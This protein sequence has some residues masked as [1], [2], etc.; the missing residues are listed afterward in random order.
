MPPINY[1]KLYL[2]RYLHKNEVLFRYQ[3]HTALQLHDLLRVVGFTRTVALHALHH[4]R[5]GPRDRP[6]TSSMV[7]GTPFAVRKPFRQVT[8]KG[9]R[10]LA[11]SCALFCQVI[12][13]VHEHERYLLIFPLTFQTRTAAHLDQ[14]PC[15]ILSLFTCA[16]LYT[17]DNEHV[18]LIILNYRYG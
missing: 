2:I 13:S 4:K 15:P 12:G 10:F 18:F 6:G 16:V 11:H 1:Q 7:N 8:D 9:F 14:A 5:T 17:G 3:L